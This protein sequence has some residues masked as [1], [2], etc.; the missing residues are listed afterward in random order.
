MQDRLFSCRGGCRRRMVVVVEERGGVPVDTEDSL[1]RVEVGQVPDL[2]DF[3]DVVGAA[4]PGGGVVNA[5]SVTES[6]RGRV[7]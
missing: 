3:I 5:S 4:A 6:A 7:V 1:R 2:V